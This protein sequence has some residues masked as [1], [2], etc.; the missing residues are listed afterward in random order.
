LIRSERLSVQPTR[1]KLKWVDNP[2]LRGVLP[3]SGPWAGVKELGGPIQ[4]LR[5]S[6]Q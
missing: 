3:P 4:L 5:V 1:K 6:A 2:L